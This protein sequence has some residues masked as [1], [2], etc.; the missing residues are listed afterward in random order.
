MHSFSAFAA[1]PATVR[2]VDRTNQIDEVGDP[3]LQMSILR[4]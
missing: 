1:T 3:S 2:A 4:P